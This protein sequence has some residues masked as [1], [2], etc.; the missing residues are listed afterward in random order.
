[1]VYGLYKPLKPGV[2]CMKK[3]YTNV[4]FTYFK[5]FP[6]HFANEIII[7]KNSYP[8][9]RRRRIM[10][11]IDMRWGDEGMYDNR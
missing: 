11:N 4:L 7:N 5:R 8:E 6:K 9:Y 3:A 10:D 1:M 2:I